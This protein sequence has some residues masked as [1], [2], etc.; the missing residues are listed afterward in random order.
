MESK[1]DL[2]TVLR[3]IRVFLSKG[4]TYEKNES[5]VVVNK[6]EA[7]SLLARF[8]EV[9]EEIKDDYELTKQT[10]EQA[11]RDAKHRGEYLVKKAQGQA[12]DVY[13]ASVLYTEDALGRVQDIMKEASEQFEKT[14][15]DF[16]ETLKQNREVVREN[17]SELKEQLQNMKDT[18]KY[19]KMI[20]DVNRQREEEKRKEKE[21]DKKKAI[22]NEQ[23]RYAKPE[24]K[25]NKA[26]FEAHGI[27]LNDEEES[28]KEEVSV[29]TEKK[30]EAPEI[31]VNLDSEYF[32]WKNGEKK[33]EET[34]SVK[35]SQKPAKKEPEDLYQEDLYVDAPEK[36][37]ESDAAREKKGRF[38]SFGKK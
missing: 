35:E 7:Y 33:L 26:Y 6:K 27:P 23:S 5:F 11:E 20:E 18:E 12:E 4:R 21:G 2:E 24:I 31:H 22:R 32:K 16:T 19:L 17:Q 34:E 15:K 13:A 28:E 10:R 36:E 38:F 30:P 29:E 9:L 25:I 37:Q 8:M 1:D 3:D 14:M